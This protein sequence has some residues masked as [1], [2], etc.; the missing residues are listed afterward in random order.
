M[1]DDDDDDD[2]DDDNIVIVKGPPF[3][4]FCVLCQVK[5]LLQL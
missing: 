3:K 4:L 2:D 5:A 1:W